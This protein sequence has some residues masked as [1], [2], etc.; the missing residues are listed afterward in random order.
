MS[1]DWCIGAQKGR[2]LT[3][4]AWRPRHVAPKRSRLHVQVILRSGARLL[5]ATAVVPGVLAAGGCGAGGR[6]GFPEPASEQGGKILGLWQGS[7][8]VALAVGALVWALIVWTVLRYRRR[9]DTLPSQEPENI[10]VEVAYTVAPLLVVAA[11]FGVTVFT[12]EEVTA[13]DP[14]PDLVVEVT[15]FQWSWEFA[16]P[17]EGVEVV[18]NGDDPPRL[19]LPVGATVRFELATTDVNHSFWVPEFLVKR[20]L[21]QG[22]ENTIDVDVERA[23]EWTGRCAE[24]CGLDHWKMNFA[25]SAVPQGEFDRWVEAEQARAR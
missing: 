5:S 24:F 2:Y 3:P 20:D 17:D 7:V 9:D 1:P 10:P 4:S 6:F 25:V 19:V 8:L 11:L 18:S 14:D 12:Q 15:G 23:G 22:V 21:I 13:S 16:Y